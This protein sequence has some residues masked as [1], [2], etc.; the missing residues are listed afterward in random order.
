MTV[1]FT[2]SS[3]VREWNI[4]SIRR[5]KKEKKKVSLVFP[6]PGEGIF[7]NVW[8]DKLNTITVEMKKDAKQIRKFV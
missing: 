4:S 3:R 5:K 2:K 8:D 7:R 1:L 6:K